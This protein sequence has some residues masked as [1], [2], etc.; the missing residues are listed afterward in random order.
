MRTGLARRP[1]PSTRR[2]GGILKKVL[3]TLAGALLLL[4]TVPRFVSL[5]GL[6]RATLDPPYLQAEAKR[7]FVPHPYLI[8]TPRPGYERSDPGKEIR[9]GAQGFRG[10]DLP[11]PKPEG[12][13][14]I[15]CLGGSSTYATGP[16]RDEFT[17]PA[18]LQALLEGRL[19]DRDVDVLNGG[20]PSW[21]SFECL[22]NLAFRVLPYEPDIVLVYL[23]TNDAEAALWPDPRT[24]NS[25]YR[26]AWPTFR[27]SPL[28]GIFDR[29]V[30][31]LVWRKYATDYLEQRADLGFHGKVIPPGSVGE[32]LQQ[33]RLPEELLDPSDVGFENFRRNLV[34]ITA[35]ARAH[36]ATPVL[37]TQAIWSPEPESDHMLHGKQRL[38]AQARMTDIVREV[39]AGEDVPLVEMKAFLE[40]AATEQAAEGGAQGVFVNNVH[41]TDEGSAL[42]AE[43]LADELVRLGVL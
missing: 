10:D 33:Y 32:A 18:R 20:V 15:A 41:L 17:W 12:T 28:E 1:L 5:P 26:L 43:R 23:S 30:T 7:N 39:A 40:D 16:T 6:D 2:A 4:E 9:H 13:L 37:M 14:R 42:F 38:A 34:S 31:Y 21:N 11:L 19:A 27:E 35:L 22:G 8:F 36:G 29:S 3:L 24:D 25:H